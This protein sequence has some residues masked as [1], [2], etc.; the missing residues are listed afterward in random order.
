MHNIWSIT[1]I[2]S[3]GIKI[4]RQKIETSR[5][6]SWREWRLWSWF[7]ISFHVHWKDRTMTELGSSEN[8]TVVLSEGWREWVCLSQAKHNS[9]TMEGITLCC[10]VCVWFSKSSYYIMI[11]I[12][13][14]LHGFPETSMQNKHILEILVLQVWI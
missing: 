13:T 1:F 8:S 4:M 11:C 14:S 6:R 5:S 12:K 7:G 9:F 10:V 2:L 3:L